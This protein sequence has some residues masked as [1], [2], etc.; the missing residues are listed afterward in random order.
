MCYFFLFVLKFKILN[1]LKICHVYAQIAAHAFHSISWKFEIIIVSHH[2]FSL[3]IIWNFYK[4]FITH[5]HITTLSSL[6]QKRRKHNIIHL[7]ILNK[8]QRK[9][10]IWRVWNK[11][12]GFIC[13]IIKCFSVENVFEENIFFFNIMFQK[14][15]H[16]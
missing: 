12:L 4:I 5:I 11:N 3:I 10:K 8:E 15:K 1:T 14:N 2:V 6:S 13:F 7:K 16:L 9:N